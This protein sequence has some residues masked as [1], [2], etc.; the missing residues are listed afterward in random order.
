MALRARALQSPSRL[1]D[2]SFQSCRSEL[3]SP[4]Q[5]RETSDPGSFPAGGERWIAEP[6]FAPSR[7]RSWPQAVTACGA[8]VSGN[9]PRAR[10]LRFTPF[11]DSTNFDPIWN[12]AYNLLATAGML[13]LGHAV[14]RGQH[15]GAP[16]PDDKRRSRS[17]TTELTWTF[18]RLRSELGFHDGE[19][20]RASDAVASI[21]RWCARDPIGQ[22]IKATENELAPV[23]D[24]TFR[25]QLKRPFRR[26][27][28]ALGKIGTPCCFIMPERIAL[29]DPFKQITDYVGS[30]PARFMRD[31]WVPGARAVFERHP[32]YV[33]RQEA[34]ILDL[35]RQD[36]GIQTASNGRS[37][38]NRRRRQPRCRMARLTGGSERAFP[39]W[40][41]RFARTNG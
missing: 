21:N 19:P 32:G 26:M 6:L 2:K 27:L 22:M 16:T 23:N 31:E 38:P 5:R 14:W 28:L 29:T 33:P 24:R 34:G 40:F 17:P 39:I 1:V 8:G 30:G 7:G 4:R 25:W 15:V 11:A 41:P 10:V 13:D 3:R 9:P 18:L 12:V 35:R 37:S 36:P 20:V